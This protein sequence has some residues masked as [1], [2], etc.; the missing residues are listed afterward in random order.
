MFE[1]IDVESKVSSENNYVSSKPATKSSSQL[2][3]LKLTIDAYQYL[4]L[5]SD[6]VEI[7]STNQVS[8]VVVPSAKKNRIYGAFYYQHNIIPVY[9]LKIE[10]TASGTKVYISNDELKKAGTDYYNLIIFGD[11]SNYGVIINNLTSSEIVDI[12]FADT[13]SKLQNYE[14]I[15]LKKIIGNL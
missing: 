9:K 11:E 6:I 8:P 4:V 1:T 13:K 12:N 15:D 5:L 7:K 14:I 3:Y 10:K 2:L